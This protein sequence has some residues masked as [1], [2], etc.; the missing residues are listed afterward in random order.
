MTAVYIV[1]V[2]IVG[3][4]ICA[5]ADTIKTKWRERKGVPSDTQSTDCTKIA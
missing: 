2:I 1:S 3:L 4:E 5:Y